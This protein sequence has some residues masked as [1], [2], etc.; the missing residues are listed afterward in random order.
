MKIE[1]VPFTVPDF[2]S[3]KGTVGKREDGF[4]PTQTVPLKNLE[5]SDL[6]ELCREFRESVFLKA[7]KKDPFI[8][9]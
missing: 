9:I 6:V 7:G 4:K 1:L 8:C 5:I 2:V 3:I